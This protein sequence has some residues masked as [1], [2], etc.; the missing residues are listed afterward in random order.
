MKFLDILIEANNK[1]TA[2]SSRRS[3]ISHMTF[4]LILTLLASLPTISQGASISQRECI[5]PKNS[6]LHP[7]SLADKFNAKKQL[8]HYENKEA[9]L[10]IWMQ[11]ELLRPKLK[12][13][14]KQ[15]PASAM[16]GLRPR[17][18][19]NFQESLVF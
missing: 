19:R 5:N 3:I 16:N 13:N 10:Q 17:D 12:P 2:C 14:N 7:V 11:Y 1:H 18:H 6:P 8:A 4:M 15:T 9:Y